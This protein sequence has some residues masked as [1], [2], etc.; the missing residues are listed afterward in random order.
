LATNGEQPTNN[1]DGTVGN[2][3]DRHSWG[4]N[5][6]RHSWGR[7]GGTTWTGTGTNN[8]VDRQF[9]NL[10]KH[11]WGQA[12]ANNPDRRATQQPRHN[13][14]DRHSWVTTNN[15]RDRPKQHGQAVRSAEVPVQI[16]TCPDSNAQRLARF[17]PVQGWPSPGLAHSKHAF[18]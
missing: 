16:P 10:D 5:L 13:N 2:N 8:N 15:L 7:I 3:L 11:S 6:D 14:L 12:P 4:N 18:K 1:L 17:V 9:N